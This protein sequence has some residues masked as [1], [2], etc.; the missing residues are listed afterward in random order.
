[1]IMMVMIVLADMCVN[2]RMCVCSF[3]YVS[4]IA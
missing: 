2:L 3:P 4:E 1:M